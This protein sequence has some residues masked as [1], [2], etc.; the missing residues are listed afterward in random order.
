MGFN[1]KLFSLI[2]ADNVNTKTVDDCEKLIRD[3]ENE[4]N[5]FTIPQV[6]CIKAYLKTLRKRLNDTDK[7]YFDNTFCV[8]LA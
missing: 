5:G 2:F 7:V 3:T 8:L 6:I 1:E 4:Y